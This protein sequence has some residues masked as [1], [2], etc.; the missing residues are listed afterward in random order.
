MSISLGKASQDLRKRLK[1][2]LREAAAE[3]RM[4]YVHLCNVENGKASLSLKPSNGF[5]RAW[6]ID[7]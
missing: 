1:L 2:S 3:L 6:G 4:S 5:T 7:L